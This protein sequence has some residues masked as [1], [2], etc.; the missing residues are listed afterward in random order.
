[1]LFNSRIFVVFAILFF[2]FWPLARR[3]LNVR[4]T[5]IVVFSFFFYG[6][7]DWR[8][9][10][11]LI[12][13]GLVD[14]LAGLAMTS[15]PRHKRAILL[16]S[17]AANLGTLAVFKYAF[18]FASSFN[19]AVA[20]FGGTM[21]LP[22]LSLILPVGISFYTFQSLSYTIDIYRGQLKATRNPMHFF[23]AISLFPHLVAGPIM[24]AST[25]LPQLEEDRRAT[26]DQL[27]GGLAL[28]AHG[29]F[30]KMV[31]ADNLAPFVN[32]AFNGQFAAQ[33]FLDWW[34]I[35]AMFG[36]Q[37]YCDFSGYS[38]IARG[39]AKWMG[40]EFSLNFDH[41]YLS[42]SLREFWTRWHISLSTWFRDYVYVPLGGSRRGELRGHVNM[43]ITMLLSG[44]WHGAAWTFIIWGAI[45]AFFLSV[46]RLTRWPEW[47]RR[48]RYGHVLALGLVMMQVAIAWVFFRAGSLDQALHIA[49]RMLS[50]DRLALSVSRAGLLFL[51]LAVGREIYCWNRIDVFGRLPRRTAVAGQMVWYASVLAAAVYLRGAG[52]AFIYFQF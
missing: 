23:A 38:D 6:W 5:Y 39:L 18:F 37:I 26:P 10:F 46:E 29:F 49:G 4:W 3:S 48:F 24:R 30:K 34:A 11:L 12:G 21:S 42:T 50:P 15:H 45:H 16:V 22:E 20:R 9:V 28:I 2:A 19:A 36:F 31:I 47:L 32:E 14:F 7:W 1:V 43:W 33:S 35:V 40:Y 17:L 8:Y 13:T 51:A 44:L 25:L 52:S 41:P 27:W